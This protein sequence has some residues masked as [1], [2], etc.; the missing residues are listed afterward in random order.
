MPRLTAALGARQA[1]LEYGWMQRAA[2]SPGAL[3]AM[4]ARRAAAEPLQYILGTQPFGPL[5]IQVRRPVLIPR[6]ETEHWTLRLAQLLR[7][8]RPL[9]VL[10]LGTG[11]GC[12]PL[13]LCH[14]LPPGTVRAHGIDINPAA[15]ALA[16]EN[17]ALYPLFPPPALTGPW[18]LIT[19]NP[20]YI[21]LPIWHS[22]LPPSVKDYED[23]LALIGGGP[24]GLDFYT[25][26]AHLLQRAPTFLRGLIALEVG[27]GQADA[28]QR[29]LREVAGLE[30]EVWLDPWGKKR[31]VIARTAGNVFT[32]V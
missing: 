5:S 27:D 30:S 7:P 1:A 28:V 29:I 15:V 19:C 4:V 31:T 16:A 32:T 24:D 13:L 3:A 22:T 8:L 23:P 20:P 9:R 12:I 11:T 26:I 18:D 17:T 25:K 10:D 6:P 14:V 21:P 2:Q